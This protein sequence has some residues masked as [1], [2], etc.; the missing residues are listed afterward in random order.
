MGW[1]AG[2]AGTLGIAG[3]YCSDLETFMLNTIHPN[4]DHL[5]LEKVAPQPYYTFPKKYNAN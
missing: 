5:C 4:C 2:R 3:E 1:G